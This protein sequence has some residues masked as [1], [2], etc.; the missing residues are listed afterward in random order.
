[1]SAKDLPWMLP[2]VGENP[3]SKREGTTPGSFALRPQIGTA[4][5]FSSAD[6]PGMPGIS[7]KTAMDFRDATRDREGKTQ[8]EEGR[9][10]IVNDQMRRVAQREPHLTAEQVRAEVA[11]GRMIIP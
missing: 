9:W 7:D 4:Y 5:S 3:S 2:A 1:M 10:G 8:L 11:A 6:A